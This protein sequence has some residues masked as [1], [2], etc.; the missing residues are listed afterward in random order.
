MC[1]GLYTELNDHPHREKVSWFVEKAQIDQISR[2]SVGQDYWDGH[3]FH[4]IRGFA[5]RL[6][7]SSASIYE[8]SCL[9]FVSKLLR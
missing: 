1:E 8:R 3:H 5:H 9:E 2:P 4:Y 6:L 7:Q